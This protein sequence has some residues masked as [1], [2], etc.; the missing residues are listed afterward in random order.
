MSC[1]RAQSAE[2]LSNSGLQ[3]IRRGQ[4]KRFKVGLISAFITRPMWSE[5]PMR[6]PVGQR[7]TLCIF[8]NCCLVAANSSAVVCVLVSRITVTC[9]AHMTRCSAAL[10]ATCHLDRS[11][12]A[13]CVTD[14]D[15]VWTAGHCLRYGCC[16]GTSGLHP[17]PVCSDIHI[18]TSVFDGWCGTGKGLSKCSPLA[19]ANLPEHYFMFAWE[20]RQRRCGRRTMPGLGLLLAES[21]ALHQCLVWGGPGRRLLPARTPLVRKWVGP[22]LAAC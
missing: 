8:K 12:R 4:A 16:C 9:S 14:T 22:G 10:Q 18:S 6:N 5:A 21:H 3:F 20:G 2:H 1:R 17:G 19:S 15:S 7:P 13:V 11:A